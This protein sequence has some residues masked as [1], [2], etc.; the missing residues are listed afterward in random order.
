[1]N[2]KSLTPIPSHKMKGIVVKSTGSWYE[3][4]TENGLRINCRIKGKFRTKNIESTNPVAV[5][6][7]VRIELE[8]DRNGLI[9]DIEKRDNYIIRKAT[10]LSK[11]I[12]I[13]ASNID[14]AIL[15]ATLKNPVTSTMF[16]DRFLVSAE[17]FHVPTI[18]LINKIDIYDKKTIA[19]QNKLSNT[20]SNAGYDVYAISAETRYNLDIFEG[21][22]KGRT[23]LVSGISGV[24]KSTLINAID[25]NL[26]LK[27][28][29][30]SDHHK[31]GK[32]TTTFAEMF[33]LKF[34]GFIIDTPGIKSFGLI[35]MKEGLAHRFP[36]MRK[37][38]DQCQFSNCL[39]INEPNCAVRD[40][41]NNG[42]IATFR[43]NNYLAMFNSN[44]DDP[45]RQ[46][47]Y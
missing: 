29:E 21:M 36:E 5:G 14:Q 9:T 28:R 26:N 6:D 1:M 30:I 27:V 45:Y 37:I 25:P 24:G 3:V 20:Y 38:M 12:H 4:L 31:M 13:I 32:H 43:Y 10:N 7:K 18:I 35:D 34:G 44:E 39:H 41:V 22:L 47:G 17:S 15:I 11:R 16:I 42:E 33:E 46:K 2:H 8:Q 23:S 40:A 19:E